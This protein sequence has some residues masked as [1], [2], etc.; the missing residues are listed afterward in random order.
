LQPAMTYSG[1]GRPDRPPAAP[2]CQFSVIAGELRPDQRVVLSTD[3][4]VKARFPTPG[5][6]FPQTLKWSWPHARTLSRHRPLE[7]Q[8]GRSIHERFALD[9]SAR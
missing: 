6:E 2:Y 8:S 1:V 5:I 4:R 3:A 7:W 9:T